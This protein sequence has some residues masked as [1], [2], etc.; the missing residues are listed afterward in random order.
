VCRPVAGS[1]EE[2]VENLSE[3]GVED[4]V[5]DWVQSAVDVA[6]QRNCDRY[7]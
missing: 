7:S 5:D 3:L 6:E 2:S 1:A 4:R